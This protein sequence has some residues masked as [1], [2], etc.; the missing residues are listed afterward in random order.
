MVAAAKKKTLVLV[1]FAPHQSIAPK[2]KT[3]KI[4]QGANVPLSGHREGR[5]GKAG[6]SRS[7]AREMQ[8]KCHLG[9]S[10]ESGTTLR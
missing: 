4:G 5:F 10:F 2:C 8:S 6:R 9:L 1:N 7:P 3:G